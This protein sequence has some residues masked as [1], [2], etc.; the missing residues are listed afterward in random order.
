MRDGAD[1][2]MGER[3]IFL[4]GPNIIEQLA[5]RAGL[6][7][8]LTDHFIGASVTSPIGSNEVS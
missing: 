2:A 3:D 7:I 6:E 8:G 4:V 5:D 1:A